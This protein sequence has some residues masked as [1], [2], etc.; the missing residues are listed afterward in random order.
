MRKVKYIPIMAAG[1]GSHVGKS[2][3]AMGLC[4]LF[5]RQGIDV[6]PFKAQN[7]A[8]NSGI[9]PQGVEMGRAQISQ[10]EAAGVAP[11]TDMN[12][13][14]LKP[15]SDRGSQVIVDGKVLGNFSAAEYYALKPRLTRRVL[16]AFRR[17]SSAHQ[18]IVLEGAG[19]FCELNLKRHDLVN[20]YMARRA[21]AKVLLTAD[22]SAGGVFAQLEGT[23]RL[24][25]PSERRLVSGMVVNKFRGDPELFKDGV[26]IIEQRTGKPVLGVLPYF[27][28]ISLPQED[29][30]V[31]E[32]PPSPSGRAGQVRVGGGAP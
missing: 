9:T 19:S 20:A 14:L 24:L 10:A 15:Y 21:R 7:M 6:A 28:H 3:L 18:L 12:P 17:L 25:T 26:G 16:A 11:H 27:S 5:K 13:V 30:V 2:V 1:T 8:L 22:I 32:K 4:R 31:L 29:G 23:L